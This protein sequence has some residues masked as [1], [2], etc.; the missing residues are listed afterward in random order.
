[1]EKANKKII[2]EYFIVNNAFQN[3]LSQISDDI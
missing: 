2:Y 1:M 3:E